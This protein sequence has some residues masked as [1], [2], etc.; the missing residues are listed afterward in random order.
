MALTRGQDS[1]HLVV[2]D[3]GKREF[4]SKLPEDGE[5]RPGRQIFVFIS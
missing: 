5:R 1:K 4:R 2:K 3:D